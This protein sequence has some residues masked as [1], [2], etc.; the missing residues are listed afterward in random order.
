MKFPTIS[1]IG[2]K[3]PEG[4]YLS[5]PIFVPNVVDD[6]NVIKDDNEWIT[7]NNL[8]MRSSDFPDFLEF[9]AGFEPNGIQCALPNCEG[10]NIG[11]ATQINFAVGILQRLGETADVIDINIVIQKNKLN[12][13]LSV[14]VEYGTAK[15][16]S[17]LKNVNYRPPIMCDATGAIVSKYHLEP[18]RRGISIVGSRNMTKLMQTTNIFIMYLLAMMIR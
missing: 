1:L 12:G 4:E 17:Y 8:P 7:I 6:S 16:S 5:I 2:I 11:K 9:N 10:S 14:I 13:D 15:F 3:G 18:D